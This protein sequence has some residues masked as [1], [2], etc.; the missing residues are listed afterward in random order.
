MNADLDLNRLAGGAHHDPHSILG[1]HPS[2]EGL[3][4]RALKPLAERVELVLE[5]GTAHEMTHEAYGVFSVTLPAV[6][7]APPY[8]LRA[9][10]AGGGVH[11]AGDPYRHWPTLGEVDLHLIG[12]GR[13]ERLW[14][15]L[16]ARVIRHDD[17]DGT[18]FAVWAPNARGVRV[19][20]AFNHWNGSAHPMR[21][22][23]RSGVWELFVPGVGAGEAYKFSILGADSIW[24]SKADP[25]ARR[26]EQPPATASIV[27]DSAYTWN[28]EAWLAARAGRDALASP[29]SAYEVHLGSWRPGLSYREL[30][31]QL[32]EY[33]LEMGFTHVELLPVAEHPFGGSWGYQVTSYYAP[34]SRFGTPDEFRHLVDRLHEAGIGVLLDWVPAHFPM[35]EWALGRFDGTPLYEHA[36]PSRGTHPEWGTYIFDFGRRE[37]RNFLVANALYWLKEFHI[38][39]LRVDAVASMLYLDYSRRAGE[40][41][42]NE[43]GGRENLDAV[44]FLK[45]MNAVVYREAP[46]IVTIA[47]ESTAW[48][49]VSRPVHL[50][51]LGFGFKWNMGW[52]HDTLAYLAHE[53]VFR[54]YHHH[55]MTFSLMYAYSENFVLPLSH[56]EVVHGKGSLLGKMPGDEWQRFSNLRALFAFMWAHPGKQLLFMGSEFGQGSEWSEERGLD[57]WVLDFEPHRGVQRL[58]R[59]LNRVYTETRALFSQDHAPQGFQWIDADDAQGNVFSFARHGDDGSMVACVA[60]FSGAPHDDY[61]IGLP[62]GGRWDEVINTDAYEYQGSG[63]GN[64]GGVDA[65]PDPWHGQPFSARLRVPPL[66]ALW[67]RRVPDPEE[68]PATTGVVATSGAA[69]DSPAE[70]IRTDAPAVAA[71]SAA[72][73]VGP[74]PTGAPRSGDATPDAGGPDGDRGRPSPA[75][76]GPAAP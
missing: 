6:D 67:L 32:V 5:D 42:P 76:G 14:E 11:E 46:G 48:P 66:G 9:G 47:E 39:G 36:D 33:V 26:T 64:F 37:V 20:G 18:A 21:S 74:A 71:E 27:D 8:R 43:Y 60:N 62:A 3:V 24:R 31:D 30:A 61:M 73:R 54:Q 53:P 1:T 12:E 34:T 41:T 44:E 38:D 22:L 35:D 56:D 72:P 17:E 19:E 49:G 13:H 28:D 50:G 51:G 40:W 58:V 25:M 55:Q 59:D 45:E 63:V 68:E 52:M 7:K 15:V 69:Q 2:P 10:Y 75:A 4:V 16:G 29:M 65:T 23:G 57:W 70:E